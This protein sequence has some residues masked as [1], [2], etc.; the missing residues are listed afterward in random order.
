MEMADWGAAVVN[1]ISK[2]LCCEGCE[3]Y[4]KVVPLFSVSRSV[5]SHHSLMVI[6]GL[7]QS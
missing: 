7:F 5:C 6:Y 3:L 4:M 2:F 1:N